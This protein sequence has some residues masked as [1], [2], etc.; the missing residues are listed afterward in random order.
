MLGV[1]ICCVMPQWCWIVKRV[2]INDVICGS[3][4]DVL[5]IHQGICEMLS[6]LHS[7]IY[8]DWPQRICMGK[9]ANGVMLDPNYLMNCIERPINGWQLSMNERWWGM[10]DGHLYVIGYII[11]MCKRLCS[12][13]NHRIMNCLCYGKG[14]QWWAWNEWERNISNIWNGLTEWYW[15]RP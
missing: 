13:L 4:W 8:L 11:R 6:M 9:S 1:L 15:A 3:V 2:N 14:Y 5:R 10:C 12:V 7:Y